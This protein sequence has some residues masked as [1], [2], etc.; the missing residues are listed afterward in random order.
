MITE[1]QL[2]EII[3][4]AKEGTKK[5]KFK[6]SVEI[7]INFKDIDV[8]KGFAI[9]EVVQLPKTSS[10]ATVC[11]IATGDMNQKA[12]AAKA[13]SVIGNEELSKYESNKRESRKFINKYDFFLADTQIMPTVGKALGQLLGPRGKMPTPIPFNA[14][15]DAFL[16][17]FRTSIKVRTR[18]SLS[19]SCKIGD[20]SMED[21]DLAVNA[22]TVLN[23]VEKKLPNGE[24]NIRKIMIKTTMGKPVKQL[25]E[26]KKKYA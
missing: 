24:K 14:P 11:V 9:N 4:K 20:E 21:S 25:Q 23:A 19:I 8:K 26:I 6:Q 2:A 22:F 18:A 17:R 13:D 16:S 7:I 3:T 5:R 12:K 15:I 10:P 1:A